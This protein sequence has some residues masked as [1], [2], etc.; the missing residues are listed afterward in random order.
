MSYLI[1]SIVA[2]S[3]IYL[4]NGFLNPLHDWGY[5]AIAMAIFITLE[6][7]IDALVA[8]IIRKM[9]AKRFS[10]DKKTYNLGSFER[11]FY[12][13]IR[14][15]L[16]KDKVPELGSFTGFHKNKVTNPFDNEYIGRFILE[17]CY[18]ISIHFWSVPFSFLPIFIDYRMWTGENNVG[19]T[20]A[21]PVAVVNAVLIVIPAFILKWNLPMLKNIYKNNLK[22]EERKKKQGSLN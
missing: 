6:V 16:W 4:T 12:K 21:L 19:L 13:F 15:P 10:M 18:G 5:Y 9:P 7:A 3:C 11:K 8:L 20:I 2:A 17:S 22:R 14:V 1:I